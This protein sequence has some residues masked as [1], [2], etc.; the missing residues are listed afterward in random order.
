M[1]ASKLRLRGTG[2]RIESRLQRNSS[3]L[4]PATFFFFGSKFGVGTDVSINIKRLYERILLPLVQIHCSSFCIVTAY[5]A[6][7][8]LCL[9]ISTCVP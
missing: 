8:K 7:S 6:M 4:T 9:R 1:P 5:S 2:R 3:S